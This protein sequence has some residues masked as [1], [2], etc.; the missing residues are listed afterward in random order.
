MSRRPLRFVGAVVALSSYPFDDAYIHLRLARHLAFHGEPYF[1]LGERVMSGSSPLW[2]LLLAAGFRVSGHASVAVAIVIECVAILTLFVASEGFLACAR[3]RSMTTLV[4]AFAVTVLALPSAG[5]LMET[6]LAVALFVGGLWAF[7]SERFTLAGLLLG[8][9]G[10]TRFELMVPIIGAILLAPARRDQARVLA[11]AAPVLA[12]LAAALETFYGAIVPHT[13]AAKSLVY[14]MRYMDLLDMGPQEFGKPAGAILVMLLLLATCIGLVQVVHDRSKHADSFWRAA[15]LLG[16]FP[17]MLIGIYLLKVPLIFPWYWTL[18]V[19]PMALFTCGL[20][21]GTVGRSPS[22]ESRGSFFAGF[23]PAVTIAMAVTAV[24]VGAS[25]VSVGAA[26]SGRLELAPWLMEN[27]RTRTYLKIGSALA[28]SCIGSVVAAPEIGALGWAF[29]GR[30]LDGGGLASPEVLRFHPLR[31]PDERPM[32]GIGAIP[33]RAV[34]ELQP[35]L[36]VSMELFAADFVQKAKTSPALSDYA[37]W[38]K[39]P[40]LAANLHPGLPE[41][42]WSSRWT[43]V[44]SR[45]RSSQGMGCQG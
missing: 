32:G 43:L 9:A 19:C 25:V 26:I 3:G 24:L 21:S 34:A 20:A 1:N 15:V 35:D 42:L 45:H 22:E 12:T 6:P 37:V 31:V 10:C 14:Q 11:G 30:I 8:L 40:V 5:G 27:A 18:S 17:V 13:M 39:E 2:M 16:G 4:A 33:G 36:V 28:V 41:T 44:F 23:R 7:R 29:D 38:W